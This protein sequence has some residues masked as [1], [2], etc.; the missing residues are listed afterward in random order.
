M[1]PKHWFARLRP[2]SAPKWVLLLLLLAWLTA[3]LMS[4]CRESRTPFYVLGT[5]TLCVLAWANH[6]QFGRIERMRDVGKWLVGVLFDLLL[7]ILMVVVCAVVLSIFMP[8]YQCY[9]QRAKVG[10][11]IGSVAPLQSEITKRAEKAGSLNDVGSHLELPQNKPI[12]GGLVSATGHIVVM[13]D[14]PPAVFSLIPAMNA[15]KVEWRC[16]GYPAKYM[17]MLCRKP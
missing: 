13:L 2:A 4:V 17:P 8:S 7:L 10:G 9:T 5:A 1:A 12:V 3:F 15:G 6:V 14:D 11:A 16:E